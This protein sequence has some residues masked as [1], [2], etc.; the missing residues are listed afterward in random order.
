[1][2]LEKKKNMKK[3]K[4]SKIAPTNFFPPPYLKS[5]KNFEKNSKKIF[6]K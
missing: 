4:D 2:I 6:Q 1:M 3:K 5:R